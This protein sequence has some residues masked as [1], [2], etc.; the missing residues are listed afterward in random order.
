MPRLRLILTCLNA[1]AEPADMALPGLRLHSL[2]GEMTGLWAVTVS[3]NWCVVL[4]LD[5]DGDAT[6]V[7]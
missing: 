1:G 6:S 5:D 3:G 4:G 2:K 7:D